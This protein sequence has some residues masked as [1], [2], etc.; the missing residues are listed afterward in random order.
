MG[1]GTETGDREMRQSVPLYDAAEL[2][3]MED[4]IEGLRCS[5][6]VENILR[7]FL[8]VWL[9]EKTCWFIKYNLPTKKEEGRRIGEKKRRRRRGRENQEKR[10][11]LVGQT[12]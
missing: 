5:A 1:A 11:R 10:C 6:H 8:R 2:I 7:Y 4:K 12:L 3:R 9:V